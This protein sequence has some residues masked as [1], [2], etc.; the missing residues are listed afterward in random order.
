MDSVAISPGTARA[1]PPSGQ[2]P[3]PT[4]GVAADALSEAQ[5]A[6][7]TAPFP[8]W[9]LTALALTALLAGVCHTVAALGLRDPGPPVTWTGV[10]HWL[11]V[12]LLALG[13]AALYAN[14][15]LAQERARRRRAEQAL[16][17]RAATF[18]TVFDAAPVGIVLLDPHG[19]ILEANQAYACMA[20]LTP[21]ALCQKP[22]FSSLY[23]ADQQDAVR[24][25]LTPSDRNHGP[26]PAPRQEWQLV[27]PDHSERP[28]RHLAAGLT[29]VVSHCSCSVV[30][31]EDLS[32]ARLAEERLRHAHTME[33]VG[34]LA[35]GVAHDFNNLL[36]VIL[37]YTSE[38][39]E[40]LP[41]AE[42]RREALLR[43]DVAAQRAARLTRELLAFGRRQTL[44][45]EDFD[46]RD[47][48]QGLQG[49]LARLARSPITLAL[50]LG[51]EPCPV[52]ADRV[53][54]EQA[55]LNLCLNA[56]DAMPS[57]GRLCLTTERVDLQEDWCQDHG[58]ARRGHYV[59]V[60]V[61]DTGVGMDE[62]TLDQ[63]FAPCFSTRHHGPGLAMG[64][65]VAFS[66]AGQHGGTVA[67]VSQPGRGSTFS[68]LIPY[69]PKDDPATHTPGPAEPPTAWPPDPTLPMRGIPEGSAWPVLDAQGRH[70][71]GE[72]QTGTTD[73]ALHSAAPRPGPLS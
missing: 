56:R 6:G 42:P 32:V 71:A 39:L 31:V 26:Q 59:A 44:Q 20:G 3:T 30:I 53:Q 10:S 5:A 8:G 23:R 21:D 38:A 58:C 2:G 50:H 46:L 69:R 13:G 66:I 45:A 65:A 54:I 70:R 62:A 52:H 73:A 29:E 28:V 22:H 34:L 47:L 7:E 41:A 55:I 24:A 48:V 51:D 57:G 18:R 40:G 15:H 72:A 63:L 60:R 12:P 43:V 61:S 37:G 16:A 19:R 64:L 4:H 36:Q 67:A 27:R 17:E 33:V 49:A 11:G 68:I 1:E 14:R 9:A 25:H 35:A